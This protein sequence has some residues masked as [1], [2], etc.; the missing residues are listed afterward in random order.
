[1][2]ARHNRSFR[3]IAEKRFCSSCKEKIGTET[4]ERV[5]TLDPKTG[6]V[7]YEMRTVPF[8]S[9]PTAVIRSCCSKERGYISAE[10]PTLEAIFRVFLMNGNQP[11]DLEGIRGE[12]SQWFSLTSRA[13]GYSAE[14]L[15]KLIEGDDYYGLREFATH[16]EE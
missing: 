15:R 1:W 16:I 14:L 5:P 9:N 6:R 10:M 4:Q 2:Y 11:T 12:L 8:G 13:H 3:V 7:I